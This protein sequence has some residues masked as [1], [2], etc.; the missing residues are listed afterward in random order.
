MGTFRYWLYRLRR[1]QRGHGAARFVPLVA[2][3]SSAPTGCRL[4]VGQ[5]ELTFPSLPEPS[6]LVELLRVMDR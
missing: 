6:Y 1:A 3:E 2:S 5:I 4:R